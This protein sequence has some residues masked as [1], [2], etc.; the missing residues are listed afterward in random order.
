[1]IK[2]EKPEKP[3]RPPTPQ[4]RCPG[5]ET[6]SMRLVQKIPVEKYVCSACG[7]VETR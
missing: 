5:C 2:T 3:Q 4:I 6:Y 1:M 7:Y